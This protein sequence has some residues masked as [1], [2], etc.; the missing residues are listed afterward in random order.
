MCICDWLTSINL[1]WQENNWT[2]GGRGR[3]CPVHPCSEPSQL[4]KN[5]HIHTT[6]LHE[7]ATIVDIAWTDGQRFYII[8]KFLGT[9]II[10]IFFEK[11]VSYQFV[12]IFGLL[13]RGPIIASP[14]PKLTHSV[15]D[16]VEIWL[17][18]PWRLRQSKLRTF[19]A[20]SGIVWFLYFD[21]LLDHLKT[22]V[23]TASLH[24]SP[25]QPP[26]WHPWKNISFSRGRWTILGNIE[27]GTEIQ[28]NCELT[29]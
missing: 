11:S 27:C 29:Y 26:P 2:H 12:S 18:W 9:K 4:H 1:L 7:F 13:V 6:I 17:M 22:A 10:V 23:L 21:H 3:P 25:G 5:C 28:K 19:F 16:F 24:Q 14:C 15:A 8:N 20:L